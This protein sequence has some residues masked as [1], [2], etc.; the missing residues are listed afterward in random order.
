MPFTPDLNTLNTTLQDLSP[1]LVQAGEKA[2]YLYEWLRTKGAINKSSIAGT[3]WSHDFTTG[4]SNVL[5]PLYLGNEVAPLGASQNILQYQVQSYR[6]MAPISITGLSLSLNKGRAG[7]VKLIE[8]Q[9]KATFAAMYRSMNRWLL[10]ADTT[11]SGFA[12]ATALDGLATLNSQ[13]TGTSLLGVNA[14]LLSFAAPAAQTAVTQNVAKSFVKEHYNQ[15]GDVA[16]FA[17]DNL[18]TPIKVLL[19]AQE[20]DAGRRGPDL[21]ICDP[22]SFSNLITYSAD[23]VRTS[24]TD[25]AVIG[26]KFFETMIGS[27]VIRRDTDL[28]RSKFTGDAAD[29]VC[30]LMNTDYISL[31]YLEMPSASPFTAWTPQQDAVASQIIGSMNLMFERFNCHGVVTGMATP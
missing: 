20:F 27:C 4:A 15:Y 30:Y 28:D 8:G 17:A 5:T 24:T 18:A 25:Q 10:S 13:H 9:P 11:V 16:G 23:T 1:D 19:D 14:G 7:I 22:D 3:F 21:G 6:F 12:S 26:K 2:C 29:G 31:N